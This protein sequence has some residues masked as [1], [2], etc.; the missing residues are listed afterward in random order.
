[1]ADLNFRNIKGKRLPGVARKQCHVTCSIPTLFS[2]KFSFARKTSI[3]TMPWKGL[4]Q[5][6][7]ML[8]IANFKKTA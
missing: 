2:N 1:M 8:G 3:N 4:C 6:R 7:Q 5:K